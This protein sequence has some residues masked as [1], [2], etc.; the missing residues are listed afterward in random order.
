MP[1]IRT[2]YS[3]RNAVGKIDDVMERLREVHQELPPSP[4]AHPLSVG[5]GGTICARNTMCG[6]C[7][8]LSWR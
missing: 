2:G 3:F 5:C 8:G 7:S 4:T 1:R 6:Q